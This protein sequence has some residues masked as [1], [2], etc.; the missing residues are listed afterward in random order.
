MDPKCNGWGRGK[1]KISFVSYASCTLLL[2]CFAFALSWT[3]YPT[4]WRRAN[5]QVYRMTAYTGYRRKTPQILLKSGWHLNRELSLTEVRLWYAISN[6]IHTVMFLLVQ[7]TFCFESFISVSYSLA[8]VY[9]VLANL[10]PCLLSGP[11]Y[12]CHHLLYRSTRHGQLY[13]GI[14]SLSYMQHMW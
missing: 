11:F 5:W 4:G 14:F 3:G 1:E 9:N 12:S 10:H 7:L 8:F 6:I 2:S 13:R